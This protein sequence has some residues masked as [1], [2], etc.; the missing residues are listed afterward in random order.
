MSRVFMSTQYVIR[1]YCIL[2]EC[3]LKC[4]EML[5]HA[6]RLCGIRY[7]LNYSIHTMV[8]R[9]CLWSKVLPER[10]DYEPTLSTKILI[11]K[12]VY[13][14]IIFPTPRFIILSLTHSLRVETSVAICSFDEFVYRTIL[15]SSLYRYV[16]FGSS[17]LSK[18]RE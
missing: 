1:K 10:P 15:I 5:P 3:D 6:P 12:T 2:R 17:Y 8:L 7:K 9:A 4:K 16:Y 11:K 13:L 18:M 14:V